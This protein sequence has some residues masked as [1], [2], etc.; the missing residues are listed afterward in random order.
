MGYLSSTLVLRSRH[1][2]RYRSS[3]TSLCFESSDS[4]LP[5]PCPGKAL[6]PGEIPR[7]SQDDCW[8]RQDMGYSQAFL[9]AWSEAYWSCA[10]P[11]ASMP[12]LLFFE[13]LVSRVFDMISSAARRLSSRP[14]RSCRLPNFVAHQMCRPPC[15]P[16][17]FVAHPNQSPTKSPTK[18]PT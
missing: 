2:F 10:P 6:V 16:P 18:S 14:P 11:Q 5:I 13:A 1:L 7:P 9:L 17:E 4:V 15:R 8:S 12:Q 3:I